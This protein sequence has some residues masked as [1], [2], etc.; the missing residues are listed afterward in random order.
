[1]GIYVYALGATLQYTVYAD[2]RR[3]ADQII[4]LNDSALRAVYLEILTP[5]DE[6]PEFQYDDGDF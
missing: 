3:E 6:I 1:M 2:T 5:P 4:I